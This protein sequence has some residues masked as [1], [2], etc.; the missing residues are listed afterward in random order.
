ME[1]LVGT[2]F[3]LT[4]LLADLNNYKFN[5][6][7][8]KLVESVFNCRTG[9][10]LGFNLIKNSDMEEFVGFNKDEI[11]NSIKENPDLQ[12]IY[13]S[14]D[15]YQENIQGDL[16]QCISDYWI[17]LLEVNNQDIILSF[18]SDEIEKWSDENFF[19][20]IFDQEIKEMEAENYEYF[21]YK[22]SNQG[23]EVY[24]LDGLNEIIKKYTDKIVNEDV[25]YFLENEAKSKAS[26]YNW[27]LIEDYFENKGY[28]QDSYETS[29]NYDE[30]VYIKENS[31][32]E[33]DEQEDIE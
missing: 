6:D 29:Q 1:N 13:D 4:E 11:Y 20:D 32:Y 33:E 28:K 8:R 17:D 7:F 25:I 3:D 5:P 30:P 10:G 27:S 21:T 26:S 2:K 19:T 15:N 31:G 22:F 23:T 12:K 14:M 16:I 18:L 9:C 24:N